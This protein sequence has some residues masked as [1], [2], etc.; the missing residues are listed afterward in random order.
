[1]L[2]DIEFRQGAREQRSLR[3]WEQRLSIPARSLLHHASQGRLK[4]FVQPPPKAV[5]Y[6]LFRVD[7]DASPLT[8]GPLIRL[9][10]GE[11]VGFVPDARTLEALLSS[12]PV[13]IESF[14]TVICNNLS[15]DCFRGL[16]PSTSGHTFRPVGWRAGV[17]R[18]LDG[19]GASDE[20]NAA[21]LLSIDGRSV[22]QDS[23]VVRPDHVCIRD[24]DTKRFL[25][26]LTSY[27][28]ISDLFD[29]GTFKEE[30]PPYI[31]GKLKEMIEANQVLWRKHEGLGSD[32]RVRKRAFTVEYLND[33]FRSFCK[34]GTNPDSLVKFAADAC[35]PSSL[36]NSR[37][38]ESSVTP[39]MLALVTAAKLFWSPINVQNDKPETHPTRDEI[40]AFLQFM[41][42]TGTNAASHGVTIIRPEKA[43]AGKVGERPPLFS[44]LLRR[45]PLMRAGRAPL[46]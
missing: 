38:L 21:D 2:H 24:A 25:V 29:C 37:K 3:E 14:D 23:F 40:V 35:D 15:W 28:F 22:I 32:E 45:S 11:L 33:K 34:K 31:S 27:S 26:S 41:G 30:L 19:C 1:M 5:E 4:L 46:N 17:F 20:A 7:E 36:A 8:Q 42:L 13:E 44:P 9:P 12:N 43:A 16:F 18:I 39:D 6:A 10:K